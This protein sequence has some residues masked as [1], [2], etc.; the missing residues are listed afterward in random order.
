MTQSQA[1]LKP[2]SILC[3]GECMVELR[4]E[5]GFYRSGFAGDVINFSIYL[6]RL[7]PDAAIN[8]LSAVGNDPLSHKMRAFLEQMGINTERVLTSPDKTVGLYMV[9]T[10]DDG[11][12]TFS[13]WRSDSAARQMLTLAKDTRLDQAAQNVDYFY[14]SGITLAILDQPSRERL[15]AFIER[16]IAWKK[17]IVFDPNMRPSLWP[18]FDVA[19]SQILRA[20]QACNIL[21]SSVDDETLLFGKNTNEAIIARLNTYN[22]D[23]IVLTDGPGDIHSLHLKNHY[24]QQAANPLSVVD[25][26]SA[27]DGF[28]AAYL[29]NRHLGLPVKEAIQRASELSALIIAHPGAIVPLQVT[30]EHSG[31]NFQS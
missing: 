19:R 18:T 31:S 9:H 12:R 25:T 16:L 4:N 13:Y 11:E 6:K 10:D 28:N 7:L 26:T 3:A 8:L 24:I 27:G 21:L 15:F 22:I 14:F 29:V 17:T 1:K 5:E 30:S 20:Y 23:E 2:L